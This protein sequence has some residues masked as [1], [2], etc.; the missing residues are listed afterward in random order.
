MSVKIK[1]CGLKREEDI[2]AVNNYLPDYAGFVFAEKSKRNVTKEQ[3]KSLI[4]KL[5]K[6]IKPV[7][8]FVNSDINEV[9]EIAEY[10]NLEVIQLHGDETP[11][12]CRSIKRK[13]W[14]AL[15]VN[16]KT[17]DLEMEKYKNSCEAFVLDNGKGG[18][19]EKFD[20]TIVTQLSTKYTIFLAGG[21]YPENVKH[22]LE[23]VRP[24][25]VDVSSGVETEGVKDVN[26]I[27]RF[28]ENAR[29]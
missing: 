12:M 13:V 16:D 17:I 24:H 7:G 21:L 1:I 23:I 6:R 25:G 4:E 15:S 29:K 3:A 8:V 9:N 2:E 10:C 18:T 14:R 11:E 28:I 26:K 19:G 20:W 5:D 27:R 22:A